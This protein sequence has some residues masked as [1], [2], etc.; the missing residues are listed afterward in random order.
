MAFHKLE[1]NQENSRPS[2]QLFGMISFYRV[3][4]KRFCEMVVFEIN[5]NSH[6]NVRSRSSCKKDRG[7]PEL[8]QRVIYIPIP[9]FALEECFRPSHAK[10]RLW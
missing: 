6:K 2:Q 3:V 4:E 7:D 1:R 5:Y 10:F 9:S 8:R